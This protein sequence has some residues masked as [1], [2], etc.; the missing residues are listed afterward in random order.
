[1]NKYIESDIHSGVVYLKCALMNIIHGLLN[2]E[3]TSY[4]IGNYISYNLFVDCLKELG[5]N[6]KYGSNSFE[7]PNEKGKNIIWGHNIIEIEDHGN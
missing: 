5:F 3:G 4:Y 1:M 2:G 6:T 7:I